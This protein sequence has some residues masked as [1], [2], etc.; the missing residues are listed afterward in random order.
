MLNHKMILEF[1]VITASLAIFVRPELWCLPVAELTLN[2]L[3]WF[4]LT[5]LGCLFATDKHFEKW[6]DIFKFRQ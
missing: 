4:H 3:P 5:P 2:R 1:W 6:Q